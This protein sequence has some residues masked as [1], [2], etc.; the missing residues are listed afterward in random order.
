MPYYYYPIAPF[1]FSQ[2]VMY[3]LSKLSKLSKFH[4]HIR[5]PA[6]SARQEGPLQAPDRKA[7]KQVIIRCAGRTR[8]RS[9]LP[10]CCSS[11]Y[12]PQSSSAHMSTKR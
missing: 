9:P 11:R 6:H 1:G 2:F 4:F 3:K 5:L 10:S 12:G 8:S 7:V